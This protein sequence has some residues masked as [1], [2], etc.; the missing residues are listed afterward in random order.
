MKLLVVRFSSIGDIVLTTPIIRCLK[1]QLPGVELH[2]LAK[3]KFKDVLSAN[4][5]VDKL[6]TIHKDL[7]EVLPEL[8]QEGFDFVAD[9]HNNLRTVK[10]K[11]ALGV[12]NAAFPK[13]NIRKWLLVRAK[14]NLMP[15]LSIVDR[16]FKAVEPLGVKQD[17]LGL[18][19]F[20]PN[21]T[22][23]VQLDLPESHRSGFVACV[24]GGTYFTKRLPVAQWQ[25][26]IESTP[27]PVVVI[28]GPDDRDIGKELAA[29]RPGQVFNAAGNYSLNESASFLQLAKLVVAND[30]GFMHIAAAFQK[31]I[32]SL[33]GNTTPLFGMYPYYGNSAISGIELPPS[34]IM[35][36]KKLSCHPCSKLGYH[37]CPK[38]H[39]KCMYNLDMAFAAK[40][41]VKIWG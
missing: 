31:P 4:P 32:I 40:E 5:Y 9:L 39:F 26:F 37:K 10:L 14:V 3:A 36:D 38:G 23:N 18:D 1:K 20:I 11:N 33:W 35:E 22:R 27:Y 25:R 8:E 41:A 34:I 6:H 21:E 28:G 17:G 29:F 12:K 16:Y 19:Y 13:L 24:V 7:S 30:T 2:F 15:D